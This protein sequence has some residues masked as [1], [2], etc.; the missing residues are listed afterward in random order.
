MRDI[1]CGEGNSFDNPLT[2]YNSLDVQHFGIDILGPCHHLPKG[3]HSWNYVGVALEHFT[4][5]CAE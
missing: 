5:L 4:T 1:W 2:P 3:W